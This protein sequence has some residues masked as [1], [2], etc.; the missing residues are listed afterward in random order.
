METP[1]APSRDPFEFLCFDAPAKSS[2]PE[3]LRV[4]ESD[5]M[6]FLSDGERNGLLVVS[7]TELRRVLAAAGTGIQLIGPQ[8]TTRTGRVTKTTRLAQMFGPFVDIPGV[9]IDSV[10]GTAGRAEQGLRAYVGQLPAGKTR[11]VSVKDTIFPQIRRRAVRSV[12][13]AAV[14]RRIRRTYAGVSP[15]VEEVIRQIA[16]LAPGNE[17][18]LILGETGV[19]KELIA[20]LLHE[21]SGRKGALVCIDATNVPD[22]LA[23]S[24]LFG[25]RAGAGTGLLDRAGFFEAANGGTVFIDEVGDLSPATQARLLRVLQN[26]EIVRLGST[27]PIKV[28]VKVIAATNRN[29]A[30]MVERGLFR[31]DLY[32]RLLVS[33]IS[34]PPLREHRDDVAFHIQRAW[35]AETNGES[36]PKHLAKLLLKRDWPGNVRQLEAF[37]HGLHLQTRLAP[38]SRSLVEK[39]LRLIFPEHPDPE[40]PTSPTPTRRRAPSGPDDMLRDAV[41]SYEVAR[42]AYRDVEQVLRPLVENLIAEICPLAI[43]RS[44]TK[45]PTSLAERLQRDWTDNVLRDVRDLCGVRIIVQ[46]EHHKL[47]LLDA[48]ERFVEIER[49]PYPPGYDPNRDA[50][51]APAVCWIRIRRGRVKDIE[52]RLGT[53]VAGACAGHWCELQLRTTTEDVLAAWRETVIGRLAA[54]PPESWTKSLAEVAEAFEVAQGVFER[55]RRNATT[56]GGHLTRDDMRR[57]LEILEN[58]LRC[59]PNDPTTAARAGKLALHLGEFER[60][61]G[62]MS[63]YEHSHYGPLLRDLGVALCQ[64]HDPGSAKYLEGIRLL[65]RACAASPRDPEALAALGGAY[66]RMDRPGMAL[67]CYRRALRI[68]DSYP[69][70]LSG[71]LALELR[72]APSSD[73]LAAYR[74]TLKLAAQRCREEIQASVRVP[75]AHL[76][77]GKFL[78]LL[79]KTREG[80]GAYVD[81][82]RAAT[83]PF[84]FQTSIDSISSLLEAKCI[85]VELDLARR[86][87]A[88][89]LCARFP[90]A[91]AAAASA[92]SLPRLGRE[93]HGPTLLVVGHGGGASAD[94]LAAL[95]G[96]LADALAGFRGT[97]VPVGD[98]DRAAS[99]VDGA[100]AALAGN[101]RLVRYRQAEVAALCSVAP[102]AEPEDIF[103]PTLAPWADLV[104]A[105]VNASSVL[106]LALGNESRTAPDRHLARALGAKVA[107]LDVDGGSAGNSDGD[108]LMIRDESALREVLDHLRGH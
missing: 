16:L 64:I 99:V 45:T 31:R 34:P 67:N 71:L 98:L 63:P 6:S 7:H 50:E 42:S 78:V 83:A 39:Q 101:A 56:Y 1:H 68:D 4:D 37:L 9:A 97:V 53:E 40:P 52:R 75:F 19:G 21:L 61:R 49:G 72:D 29:L 17:T 13:D 90:S 76:N 48:L 28:D 62:I 3:L 106:L 69:Y 32:Q 26:R 100:C 41:R 2:R 66:L 44:R 33:V 102:D 73:L 86:L 8:R 46:A 70:A 94:A 59:A 60:A 80:L 11:I 107:I 51:R 65:E 74:P 104:A 89:G 105:G 95:G 20:E 79:G 27:K 103:Y 54:P 57:E 15:D 82:I 23:E 35:R 10:Y 92:A 58:T 93:L 22:G 5:L 91:M 18:V 84:M 47:A 81:A 38:L 25:S 108:E 43:V 12:I 88:T 77:L 24:E 85:P 55:I 36:F 30:A 87:L 96:V 14:L